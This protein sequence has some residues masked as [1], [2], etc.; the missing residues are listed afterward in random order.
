MEY[1]NLFACL[2]A[3]ALSY[4]AGRRTAILDIILDRFDIEAEK[5]KYHDSK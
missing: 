2:V 4:Y 1:F 5:K 3:C